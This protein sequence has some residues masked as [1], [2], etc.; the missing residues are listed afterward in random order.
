MPM[1]TTLAVCLS[2]ATAW[3]G[4]AQAQPDRKGLDVPDGLKALKHPDPK[5]RYES[6]ALLL[7]LGPV[8]KFAIPAL[9][10]ALMDSSGYVRMK[11][12]EALWH[13]ERTPP[14]VL[15]PV[16]VDGLRD[17]AAPVRINALVVLGQ[18]GSAAKP[19]VPSIAR[20]LKDD[21]MD[22]RMEAVLT[23][24]EL[25]PAARETVPDLLAVL[26]DDELRLLEPLV[27]VAL[28]NIGRPAVE[29][30]LK[31]LVAKDVRLRRT[32][33]YALGL[34]GPKAPE[35]VPAL[36][37]ALLDGESDV[38]ALAAKA[39]GRIGPE[40]KTAAPRLAA[41]LKDK[42]AAVRIHAALALRQ[43]DGRDDG[44]PVLTEALKAK[45]AHVR[46]QACL[47]L[48]GFGGKAA[49]AVPALVE[50][51]LRDATPKVRS[52]AAEALGKIGPPADVFDRLG[53]ALKDEDEQVRLSVALA[54]WGKGKASLRAD[55]VTVAT[56]ALKSQSASIRKRAAVVL[57]EFGA[58]A[59]EAVP[60]LV[61][62]LR[63]SDATVRQAA[64]AA[65][66]RVDPAAAA[67][68]GAK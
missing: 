25:G 14:R 56:A 13:V 57:G 67:R 60:A 23:L 9:H 35:A 12:A 47:A 52:S 36:T 62:A 65:L 66:R 53:A 61:E 7:R 2:L 44:L 49:S 58:E 6:A 5:V 68:A 31:S 3:A 45:E 20:T 54:L 1:K 34:V 50:L 15:L 48:S 22:V 21:D 43:T 19:A 29:P 8:A 30:L 41:A 59:R 64:A 39:L 11:A 10:E 24:S 46:E 4:P 27:S 38:R 63:E 17:K 33:A 16:L 26:K 40:A 55:L 37:E 32:A 42:E 51:A 18:M 28:G